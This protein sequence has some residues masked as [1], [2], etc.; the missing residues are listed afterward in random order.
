[1]KIVTAYKF[2][3]LAEAIPD[4]RPAVVSNYNVQVIFAAPFSPFPPRFS[5]S[6]HLQLLN[7]I[8]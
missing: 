3:T 2:T 7:K 8:D 4:L 1:M 6:P 5:I